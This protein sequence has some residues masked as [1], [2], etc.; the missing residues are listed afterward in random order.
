MPTA[1]VAAQTAV[2]A[3]S[4]VASFAVVRT[5][6][7]VAVALAKLERTIATR[8]GVASGSGPRDTPPEQRRSQPLRAQ[9]ES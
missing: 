2:L 1:L 5:L 7:H 8:D 4:A 9:T 3:L 6:G